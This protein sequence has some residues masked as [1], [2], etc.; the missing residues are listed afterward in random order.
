M[1]SI[2]MYIPLVFLNTR[3]DKIYNWIKSEQILMSE[4]AYNNNHYI[5][6]YGRYTKVKFTK[7]QTLISLLFYDFAK[8]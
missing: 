6:V 7:L 5:I 8:Q 4:K 1:F 3:N 2:F